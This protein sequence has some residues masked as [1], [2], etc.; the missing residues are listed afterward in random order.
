[1]WFNTFHHFEGKNRSSIS[2][3]S[4][5][6][7]IWFYLL[8]V[9]N[10]ILSRPG[11]K[12]QVWFWSNQT[13]PEASWNWLLWSI[14]NIIYHSGTQGLCTW[15]AF[16]GDQTLTNFI[17]YFIVTMI[18]HTSLN[19]H[20]NAICGHGISQTLVQ[21]K[22]CHLMAPSHYLNQCWCITCTNGALWHSPKNYFK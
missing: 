7:K 17:H 15:F 8:F 4:Y 11:F 14:L 5:L 19:P 20:I 2:I 1:M 9:Y 12:T 10:E 13:R 18:L 16:C 6:L 22:A 21:A 3:Y